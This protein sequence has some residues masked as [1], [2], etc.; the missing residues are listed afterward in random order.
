M[1]RVTWS[2]DWLFLAFGAML[3]AG[4]LTSIGFMLHI[5][6]SGKESARFPLIEAGLAFAYWVSAGVLYLKF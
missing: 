3:V 2:T 6:R 1:Y 4:A 5:L